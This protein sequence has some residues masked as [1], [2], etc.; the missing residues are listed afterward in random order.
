MSKVYIEINEAT[1]AIVNWVNKKEYKQMLDALNGDTKED[2]FVG[3][4]MILPFILLAKCT[5]YHEEVPESA[6]G[7]GLEPVV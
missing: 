4:C 2:G 7:T 5:N 3:A 6:H 1:N